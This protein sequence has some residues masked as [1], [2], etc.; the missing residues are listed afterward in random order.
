[1]HVEIGDFDTINGVPDISNLCSYSQI[2]YT[3]L[4]IFLA[5][6]RPSKGVILYLYLYP[7]YYLTFY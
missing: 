5:P 6:D 2:C 7:I 3:S 4:Y 1:M